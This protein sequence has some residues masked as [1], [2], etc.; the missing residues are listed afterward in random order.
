MKK[1]LTLGAVI[2]ALIVIG[3]YS[4]ERYEE[5]EMLR[6]ARGR[7]DRVFKLMKSGTGT[8]GDIQTAVCIWAENKIFIGD[9]DLLSRYSDDFD[10]WRQEKDLYRSFERFEI[11][12]VELRVNGDSKTAVVTVK[13]DGGEPMQILVEPMSSLRWAS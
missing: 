10:R 7:V 5:K 12:A 9:R 2:V 6:K 8:G 3:R 4:L 1:L 13:V 11:S